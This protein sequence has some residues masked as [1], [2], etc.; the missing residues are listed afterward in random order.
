MMITND[1]PYENIRIIKN[2]LDVLRTDIRDL[3]DN[4][5]AMYTVCNNMED[6]IV[7]NLQASVEDLQNKLD[8][9]ANAEE[10]EKIILGKEK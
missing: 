1:N 2:R 8:G 9:R 5:D 7:S 4:I 3:F 10:L 6:F